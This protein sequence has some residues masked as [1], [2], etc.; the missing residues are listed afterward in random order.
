[1]KK[2]D[3]VAKMATD[4]GITKAQAEKALAAFMVATETALKAGDKVT[5]VGFG[6]FSTISRKARTGRNPQTGKE[7]KIAA[8]TSAK[9]SPG[10]GLKD[11]KIKA[12]KKK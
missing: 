9:F 4:A 6:T 8:K 10:K 2:A 11:L 5:L 3:L 1:M 7:I 12:A